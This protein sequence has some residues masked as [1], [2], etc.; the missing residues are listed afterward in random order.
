MSRSRV[1]SAAG[2]ALLA[3]IAARAALIA[4]APRLGFFGDHVDYVCWARESVDVGVLAP[5]GRPPGPCPAIF[6]ANDQPPQVMI[7]GSRQ[8]LNYPPP[9]AYVFWAE[10]LTLRLAAGVRIA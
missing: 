2:A 4:I 5:Y 9:A 1:V 7:S 8:R 10:C 3:G 6:Y